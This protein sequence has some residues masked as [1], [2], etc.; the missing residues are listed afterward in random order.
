MTTP[1]NPLG[2]L[3]ELATRADEW[4]T[5]DQ[6]LGATWAGLW[7]P[8]L[9]D[10]IVAFVQQHTVTATDNT[11]REMRRMGALPGVRDYVPLIAILPFE[12]ELDDSC[13][14]STNLEEVTDKEAGEPIQ[15]IPIWN[16]GTFERAK[17]T[18]VRH[19]VHLVR[20][21]DDYHEPTLA[22]A[23][24]QQLRA[25]PKGADET[26]R[27]AA[28]H[29]AAAHF[30]ER[31]VRWREIVELGVLLSTVRAIEGVLQERLRGPG[32]TRE[33]LQEKIDAGLA[34]L[35][36]V[37]AWGPSADLIFGALKQRQTSLKAANVVL[38]YE[39]Q[40]YLQLTGVRAGRSIRRHLP[41]G[42]HLIFSDQEHRRADRIADLWLSERTETTSADRYTWAKAIPA[43]YAA[44]KKRI[45]FR[46][47]ADATAVYQYVE[48]AGNAEE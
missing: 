2:P 9:H 40:T 4:R 31:P 7:Q 1:D 30:L 34:A 17:L 25:L 46:L 10:E 11:K 37:T 16:H 20:H 14:T 39:E 18:P 22:T 29:A 3:A 48:Q 13:V 27:Q 12:E 41:R 28:L 42:L 33:Q 15:G 43:A 23:R 44:Q 6:G 21:L 45:S 38:L 35:S 32:R 24:R 8:T 5:R 47:P 26:Q 19:A 36:L